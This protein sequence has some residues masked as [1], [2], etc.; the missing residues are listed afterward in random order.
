MQIYNYRTDPFSMT[1]WPGKLAS[2]CMRSDSGF[3]FDMPF[4]PGSGEGTAA[5]RFAV[6]DHPLDRSV[7]AFRSK[8]RDKLIGVAPMPN[9]RIF[10]GITAPNA[11]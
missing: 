3:L 10:A 2:S 4:F 11:D 5:L 8:A 9:Y 7:G 1:P 6:L